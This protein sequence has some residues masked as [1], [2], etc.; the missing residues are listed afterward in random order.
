[1]SMYSAIDRSWEKEINKNSGQFLSSEIKIP[2]NL[3]KL[4]WTKQ[5]E[6]DDPNLS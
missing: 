3:S 5:Q 1:M 6:M 2:S 4:D